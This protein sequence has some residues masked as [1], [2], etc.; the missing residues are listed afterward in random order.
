MS[1]KFETFRDPVLSIFQSAVSEVA[2][3]IDAKPNTNA[4]GFEQGRP[5][6]SASSIL[7][8]LALE[9]A[10]AEYNSTQRVTINT[11]ATLTP[12]ELSK[13]GITKVC[14]EMAF[15]YL[16]AMAKGD[17]VEVARLVGEYTTST[18][19]LEWATTLAEYYKYF[20]TDGNLR[21]IPYIRASDIGPSVIEIKSDAR[22]ALVSDWGTGASPAMEVLRNIKAAD[23]DIF[24][25][26]GDIYYSGTHLECKNNFLEPI[27]KILR[28]DKDIPVFTI[29]GNHDMYCGGIGFYD[30]IKT[31][32][33]PPLQQS[34][35]FFCLRAANEKWQILGLDTGLH[36]YNPAGV[37]AAITYLEEDEIEWH[38]ERIR[39]FSGRTIL[40]SHHQLFS[41]FSPI[42]PALQ[43]KRS[44]FNS[45]LLK[46]FNSMNADG[47]VSA[48]FWGHEHSLGIYKDFVGLK[49]GRCIGHGAVPVSVV[50]KIY[51][52]FPDLDN[53]PE[54]IEGCELKTQGG[55]YN[56]GH[57]ILKFGGET[58]T[59]EYYQA[60]LNGNNL[61]YREVIN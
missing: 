18:C 28:S 25:H 20:G 1:N 61:I 59:A 53:A 42:G 30:L 38:C 2:A 39:E 11:N 26:L 13:S 37:S 54:M 33:K 40:L 44:P 12:R 60:S 45:N 34:A 32:N 50:D 36:D 22:I 46:A 6:R 43:G 14:A 17:K 16:K 7:N 5:Q 8:E 10:S 47:K 57:T 49:Y 35:S 41:A 29:S 15:R 24:I 27:N 48:W 3:K 52:V 23:P 31:L 9:I 55:V 21:P 56:H 4:R 19:D 51:D 58:C